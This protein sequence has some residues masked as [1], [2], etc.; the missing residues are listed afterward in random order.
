MII[1]EYGWKGGGSD[2]AAENAS[3]NSAFRTWLDQIVRSDGAGA[4]VWMIAS[5]DADGQR[6]P[7]YDRYTIYSAQDAPSI[8]EHSRIVAAANRKADV[9]A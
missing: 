4:L 6:Y 1:E 9:Q 7:D 5:V 3:R 2:A 8:V